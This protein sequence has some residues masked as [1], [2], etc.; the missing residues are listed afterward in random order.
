MKI[1][2][3]RWKIGGGFAL[4]LL[5]LVFLGVQAFSTLN[6]A[7]EGF[8]EYRAMA[9]DANLAGGLQTDML[10]VRM[11]VKDFI[12]TGSEKDRR[13]YR[14][15]WTS[16]EGFLN[17]AKEEIQ[18]PERAEKIR[19]VA[20]AV[21]EYN[22]GFDQVVEYMQR[23][24]RL[25]EDVLNTKGPKIEQALSTIIASARQ[26]GDTD[27]AVV[28]GEAVKH[29]MLARLN[30][31][32]F[33]E[34][35]DE[36]SVGRVKQEFALM[37]SSLGELDKNVKQAED[38][39]LLTELTDETEQ[40][41][42]AFAELVTVIYDRNKVIDGTL[43]RLGPIVAKNVE[44][45]RLSVKAV[46]D[47]LGPQLVAANN[48]AVTTI[49]LV[50]IGAVAIGVVLTVFI[51]RGITGPVSRALSL[52]HA[53]RDG[54]L[55]QRLHMDQA[56]EIGQMARAIDEM[57]DELE[58]KAEVA[59]A[60]AEGDLSKEVTLAS[61]KDVLGK[62]FRKMTDNLN[63]IVGQIYEAAM[64]VASGS[65]Q[66]SDASQALSQGATEQAASLE[67]ITS[68]MTQ[69]S[70]QIKTSAENAGQANQLASTARNSADQGSARMQEMVSAMGEINEASRSIS[71]IIKVID[72]IAFQT[73][74]LALNAA[75]EAARAGRHG[76][77]FAVVAEEVRNLAARS[78]KAARETAELIDGS[79]KKVENGA[80]IAGRTSEALAEIVEGVTKVTD[81]V[82]EIAAASN[83]QAQGTAQ[84]NQ[85]L[86]QIDSVTQQNTASAEE[87]AAASE[88]LTGQAGELRQA[89]GIFK[90]RDRVI[91]QE[92]GVKSSNP[93]KTRP[94]AVSSSSQGQ[95]DASNT[96][97]SG[98]S[99]D[100]ASGDRSSQSDD[101][102][103]LDD[104]E[105]GK[106]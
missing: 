83:E 21:A 51:T 61:D 93:K 57:A 67:E 70:S 29:L 4:V 35:N 74:L 45:V 44:E 73:N 53:I 75:V 87:T 6:S 27:T 54:D 50:G 38:R 10:M 79:V 12:I 1:K 86:T 16:M 90:L 7:S 13:E 5:L 18:A 97:S 91:G 37:A 34:S 52:A 60:I 17:R 101:F 59:A 26:S 69:M 40:Y 41:K 36:A 78:A 95:T 11:N 39:R 102:I 24:D 3:I 20:E 105:F 76:K 88:E 100:D 62:S 104:D 32:K 19:Y 85:G 65:G 43:D 58:K 25:F 64:Q 80:E 47:E 49:V 68:S 46:Q 98:D 71:N 48:R 106:F 96:H 22:R 14:E 94:V 2:S 72:D 81:L 55:S 33:I 15:Y 8:E 28:A 63:R 31:M 9:R 99:A 77:G 82:G 56:D 92:T 23:R 103:A 84:I 42:K 30:V 66:V 89:L